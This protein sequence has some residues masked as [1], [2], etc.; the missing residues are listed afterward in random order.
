MDINKG[1]DYLLPNIVIA[2]DYA[3]QIQS[4][5]QNESNKNEKT[6]FQQALTDADLSVQNF[7]EVALLAKYPDISFYTEEED[8]S[9]NM[10]YFP[11]NA[12]YEI[13][14]D[15]INGTQFYRDNLGIF[16]IIATVTR[17]NDVVSAITY[18]PRK[19]V[20]YFSITDAGAFTL[21]KTEVLAQ[22]SWR[23]FRLASDNKTVMVFDD[24]ETKNKIGTE[25]TTID[26]YHDYDPGHWNLTQNSIL[27]G[28]L[29]A[30]VKFDAHLI[31]WG[32]IGHIVA[33]AGG[34]ATDAL[35][36]NLPSFRK[37]PNKRLPSIVVAINHRIHEKI[38]Q[39]L[40]N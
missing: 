26:L 13:L 33:A 11:T 21:T 10:K 1:I 18:L 23:P 27:T 15:P 28:D 6:V 30:Y 24:P 2:G 34:V 14:L 29:G 40:G 4:V 37:H 38:L 17:H 5:V 16:D 3:V 9:L 25:L 12:E 35:G 22:S 8:K 39:A 7:L 32:A 19:E 36:N 31:D 20:C